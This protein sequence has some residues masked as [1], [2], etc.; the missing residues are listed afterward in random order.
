L[1]LGI[2]GLV[3][4]QRG[5]GAEAGAAL[6]GGASASVFGA[7]GAANFLSRS[8]AVLAALFIMNSL[9]LAHLAANR[10]TPDSVVESPSVVV[11]AQPAGSDKPVTV[12]MD[13]Q[14][15]KQQAAEGASADIPEIPAEKPAQK[16]DVPATQ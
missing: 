16:S 13:Q 12:L 14:T 10:N 5:K 7:R 8:T 9:A 15:S 11:P 3:L 2:I 4:L 1:S 6:G